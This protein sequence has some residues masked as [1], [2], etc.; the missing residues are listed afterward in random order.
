MSTLTLQRGEKAPDLSDKVTE[1]KSSFALQQKP[2][3][4]AVKPVQKKTTTP[5]E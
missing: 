3:P 1:V 5:K 2:A 4:V